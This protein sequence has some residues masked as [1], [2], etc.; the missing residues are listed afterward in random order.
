MQRNF[1]LF[2]FFLIWCVKFGSRPL[3]WLWWNDSARAANPDGESDEK[4]PPQASPFLSDM[5][6]VQRCQT[7]TLSARIGPGACARVYMRVYVCVCVYV[8]PRAI[9]FVAP[10]PSLKSSNSLSLLQPLQVNAHPIYGYLFWG[11]FFIWKIIPI[12]IATVTRSSFP[13]NVPKLLFIKRWES[14]KGYNN[15]GRRIRK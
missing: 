6:E 8:H 9:M 2:F 10:I 11:F 1:F 3:K 14:L 7:C 4:T 13:E 12:T 15:R 5:E